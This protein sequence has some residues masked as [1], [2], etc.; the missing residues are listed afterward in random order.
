MGAILESM[1]KS[2][3]IRH[4]VTVEWDGIGP[5]NKNTKNKNNR[6]VCEPIKESNNESNKR[7]A[8]TQLKIKETDL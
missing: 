5:L 4:T 6:S 1:R 8:P 3:I 2:N 7:T